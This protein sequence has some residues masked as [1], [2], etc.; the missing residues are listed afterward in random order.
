MR[1]CQLSIDWLK[2]HTE[3]PAVTAGP[4]PPTF[5]SSR[6]GGGAV[7]E[8][9]GSWGI[10]ELTNSENI[11]LT[12]DSDLP[13]KW[14][15]DST[16]IYSPGDRPA[17]AS[18]RNKMEAMWPTCPQSILRPGTQPGETSSSPP[19]VF[20]TE[21]PPRNHHCPPY[22]ELEPRERRALFRRVVG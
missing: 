6:C 21:T 12:P 8:G 4:A 16:D 19:P 15:L 2:V 20:F 22:R 13:R 7:R 10:R 17:W 14:P 5:L 18:R 9:D 3:R 1:K 11:Y